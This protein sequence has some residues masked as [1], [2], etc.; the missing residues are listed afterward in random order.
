VNDDVRPAAAAS[1]GPQ[2]VS[3]LQALPLEFEAF[4]VV[5]QEAFHDY[6]EITLGNRGEA[7]DAV[8]RGFLEIH[9]N[10]QSLLAD[11][12][13]EQQAWMIMRRIVADRLACDDRPPA[14]TINGPIL[15]ALRTADL[16]DSARSRLQ[17]MEGSRGLYTAIA[18]LPNRQFDVI[19]LRFILGYSAARIAWLLG[20]KNERTVDYHIRRAKE[21]LSRQLGLP[22]ET[23]RKGARS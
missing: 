1:D 15:R 18:E 19:V 12:N 21:R 9:G 5:H 23:A 2:A 22:I 11:G 3:A 13:L 8:H 10:W 14:L 20:L 4:Y 6:A 16:L 7:E 17:L